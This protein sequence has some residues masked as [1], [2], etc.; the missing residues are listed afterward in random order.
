MIQQNYLNIVN[1]IKLEILKEIH[2]LEV[3]KQLEND[4]DFIAEV[5]NEQKIKKEAGKLPA[6]CYFQRFPAS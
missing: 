3:L 5:N 1:R 4:Q 2:E 6:F